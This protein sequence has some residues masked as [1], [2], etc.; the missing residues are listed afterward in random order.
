[1]SSQAAHPTLLIPGPIEFDDDVLMALSH[2]RYVAL[3][4]NHRDSLDLG[5]VANTR[6]S[7][8]VSVRAM[9]VLPL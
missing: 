3:Q 1:M 6:F 9:S 7:S 5:L 4:F 2:P 8:F